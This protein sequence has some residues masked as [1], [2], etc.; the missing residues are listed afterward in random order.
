M[1]AEPSGR[2]WPTWPRPTPRWAG[3]WLPPSGPAG[4][5]PTLP[6]LASRSPGRSDPS[7]LRH[8]SEQRCTPSERRSGEWRTQ[9][10]APDV[11][12]RI[13]VERMEPLAGAA[14]AG[15]GEPLRFDGWL[16]LLGVVSEL[17]AAAPSSGEDADS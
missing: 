8:P 16:E 9:R 7:V 1:P 5:A 12:I 14:G 4:T 17:V 6:I 15:G 13:W 2:R 3:T 11:L 10:E